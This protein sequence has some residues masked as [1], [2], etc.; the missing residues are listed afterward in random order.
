MVAL[1]PMVAK[2]WLHERALHSSLKLSRDIKTNSLHSRSGRRQ[3]ESDLSTKD[4]PCVFIYTALKL[5]REMFSRKREC[6]FDCFSASHLPSFRASCCG[7]YCDQQPQVVANATPNCCCQR[8]FRW[9]TSSTSWPT[10]SKTSNKEFA[11]SV[12]WLRSGQICPNLTF[13]NN[14]TPLV[15]LHAPN[16]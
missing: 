13:S 3:T 11:D 16:N 4:N 10:P 15:R 7:Q 9:A 14:R 2:L 1:A 6:L 12:T 8:I 5:G